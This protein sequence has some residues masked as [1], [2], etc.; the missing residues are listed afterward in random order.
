MISLNMKIVGVKK[1]LETKSAVAQNSNF[2]YKKIIDLK[3]KKFD[4]N[5]FLLP[6][7]FRC[8]KDF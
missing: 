5:I 6:K 3:E 8:Q 1:T 4:S 7:M 2:N